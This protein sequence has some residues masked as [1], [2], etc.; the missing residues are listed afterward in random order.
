MI[1]YKTTNLINNKIYIGQ[2]YKDNDF[3][4]LGSGKTL[5]KALKKYGKSNFKKEIIVQGDFNKLYTD[6]LEKHYIQLYASYKKNIGYN[7][8]KG[9]SGNSRN[10]NKNISINNK[11]KVMSEKARENM[12]IAAKN[13]APVSQET[14]EKMSK[15]L[16][17]NKRRAGKKFTEEQLEKMRIGIKK[18]KNT[19]EQKAL[20]SINAKRTIENGN[21]YFLNLSK[22]EKIKIQRKGVMAA[23]EKTRTPIRITNIITN[24]IFEAKTL[25]E[26][27][28]FFNNKRRGSIL[29]SINENKLFDNTY[30]I[31]RIKK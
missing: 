13:K 17:G 11:G 15:K 5:I 28:T 7:I 19:P 23:Y 6:E 21:N 20:Q 16:M 27:C 29:K 24:E 22:E 30:K 1:I 14:K 9:G 12:R 8:D 18:A 25:V 2:S 10:Q 4:Y 26:C 3:S 31:E